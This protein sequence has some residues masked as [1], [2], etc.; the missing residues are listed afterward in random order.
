MLYFIVHCKLCGVRLGK[1]MHTISNALC[2]QC[3]GIVT[4][5]HK[6]QAALIQP[7]FLEGINGIEIG[8]D[9]PESEKGD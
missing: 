3:Y 9:E 8:D 7:D 2:D 6:E 1:A 4:Q 5:C